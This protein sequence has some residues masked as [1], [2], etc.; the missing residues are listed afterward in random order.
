[1]GA[2]ATGGIFGVQCDLLHLVVEDADKTGVPANPDPPSQVFGRY[3]IVRV[4]D[5][6]VA[7]PMHFSL[8]FVE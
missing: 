4:V 1:M 3:G 7:V 5:F 8:G 6:N 2:E